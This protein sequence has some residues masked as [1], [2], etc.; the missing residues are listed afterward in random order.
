MTQTYQGYIT[1]FANQLSCSTVGMYY[2][3]GK[4]RGWGGKGASM[5][6]VGG[7]KNYC[8]RLW[9]GGLR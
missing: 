8:K 6:E 3:R 9:R 4:R 2:K 7:D 5:K 1:E